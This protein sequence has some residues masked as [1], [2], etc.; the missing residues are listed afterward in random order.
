MAAPQIDNQETAVIDG[1]L[2]DLATGE[3]LGVANEAFSVKDA[4]SAE[5]VLERIAA[6]EADA[7]RD[8]ALLDSVKERLES[9]IRASESRAEWLRGRFGEELSEFARAE[10]QGGKSKTLKMTWGSLSFRSK[11][12]ALKIV[13]QEKAVKWAEAY[14]PESVKVEK[15][16]LV[17]QLRGDW[18][19]ALSIAPPHELDERGFTLEPETETFTI[20][21]GVK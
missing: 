8:K 15:K 12:S 9:K 19:E 20:K 3:V 4:A 21:T 7:L 18:V 5:W 13:D 11:P 6:A 17:S 2:V 1:L 14:V 16:V 10:L